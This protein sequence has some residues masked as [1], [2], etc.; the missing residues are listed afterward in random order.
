MVRFVFVQLCTTFQTQMV[1]IFINKIV[2]YALFVCVCFRIKYKE[3]FL[4]KLYFLFQI[5]IYGWCEHA[6]QNP[7]P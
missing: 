5:T 3:I 7:I 2:L 4:E 6:V 1:A